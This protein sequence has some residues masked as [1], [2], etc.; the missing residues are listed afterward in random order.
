[1]TCVFFFYNEKKKYKWLF[2][3]VIWKGKKE[4]RKKNSHIT[5]KKK[6]RDRNEQVKKE[7][8]KTGK[9]KIRKKPNRNLIEAILF[10]PNKYKQFLH[11]KEYNL[12]EIKTKTKKERKKMLFDDTDD[13]FFAST[14]KYV[15]Y[16]YFYY[17]VIFVILIGKDQH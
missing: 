1:M 8:E 12:F 3:S 4:F 10:I 17:S 16:F 11:K 9:I 7:K 2:F 5:R 14:K 13:E 15:T 6:K